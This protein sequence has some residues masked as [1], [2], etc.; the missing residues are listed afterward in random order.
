MVCC[1]I[2]HLD[3]DGKIERGEL[4][5]FI[6]SVKFEDVDMDSNRSVD[7]VVVDFDTSQNSIN[8]KG[9]FI[10]RILR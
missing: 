2:R 7:Q 3:N 10:N 1:S 8:E 4:Q 5:N 9:E 6:V